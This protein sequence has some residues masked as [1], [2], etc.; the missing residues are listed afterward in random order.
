MTMNSK[1]RIPGTT[2]RAPSDHQRV[3]VLVGQSSDPV[4]AVLYHAERVHPADSGFVAFTASAPPTTDEATDDDDHVYCLHCLKLAHPEVE[5]GLL[6]ARA[7]GSAW[8]DEA[9]G[10]WIAEDED[11]NE[12]LFE[13]GDEPTTVK[14]A[15]EGTHGRDRREGR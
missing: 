4:V 3:C 12:V 6:L 9:E 14:G 5:R 7:Y 15:D 8:W 1:G 2:V 10:S 11:G 13:S